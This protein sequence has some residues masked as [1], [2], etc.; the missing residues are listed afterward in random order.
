MWNITECLLAHFFT[1]FFLMLLVFVSGDIF[2]PRVVTL[3][4]SLSWPQ[5]HVFPRSFSV[6]WFR[7]SENWEENKLLS[8]DSVKY[9]FNSDIG[10]WLTIICSSMISCSQTLFFYRQFS[11]PRNGTSAREKL[12]SISSFPHPQLFALAVNKCITVFIF[13]RALDYP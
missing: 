9:Y 13:R 11:E 6:A 7:V 5:F 8:G 4:V 3:A 12:T 10:C 1:R 2:S